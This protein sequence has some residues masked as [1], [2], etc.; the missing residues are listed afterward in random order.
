MK[1]NKAILTM[2]CGLSILTLVGCSH[3]VRISAYPQKQM[4][5]RGNLTASDIE[6]NIRAAVERNTRA[7]WYVEKSDQNKV[8]AGFTHGR[9]Y[10][11][12]TYFINGSQVYSQITDSR[13][14]NQRGDVIHKNAMAWKLRLDKYVYV[15]LAK[16][17]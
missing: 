12:V 16:A 14:L 1:L 10:L 11:Q 5:A 13:N 15:Q 8:T 4:I 17:R 7:G 2:V 6:Q 9:H 3:A